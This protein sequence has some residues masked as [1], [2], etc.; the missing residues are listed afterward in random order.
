MTHSIRSGRFDETYPDDYKPAFYKK[1]PKILHEKYT[2]AW[3]AFSGSGLTKQ[4]AQFLRTKIGMSP[5]TRKDA[6]S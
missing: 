3:Y 1:V 2:K 6:I 4:R 5:V